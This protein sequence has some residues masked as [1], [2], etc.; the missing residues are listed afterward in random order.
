MVTK[1][2]YSGGSVPPV[3]KCDVSNKPVDV[4]GWKRDD[5][6]EMQP[7]KIGT[8]DLDAEIQAARCETLPEMMA[9]MPGNSPVE[10][11]QAAV[12]LGLIVP[13]PDDKNTYDLTHE[14]AD[15]VE[16]MLLQK[17]AEA[18][19]QS[20]PQEIRD[21]EGSTIE[22]KLKNFVEKAKKAQEAAQST[23]EVKQDESK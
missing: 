9:R 15:L 13:T 11:V 10:K 22:E 19:Y 3:I 1:R 18:A 8:R 21:A 17:K 4:Y 6:G 16:A 12:N 14:P 2:Y 23:Q 20:L 5:A 7:V